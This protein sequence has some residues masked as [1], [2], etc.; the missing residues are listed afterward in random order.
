MTGYSF[1]CTFC[2]T[3]IENDV[4][5]AVKDDART[6]LA[7]HRTELEDVFALAFGGTD[8]HNDCGYAFPVGVDEVTGF[9]CPECGHDN[10]PPF[11]QQYIYWRIEA[12]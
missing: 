7:D 1:D 5:D 11:V 12:Q 8:C 4:A 9:D 2:D 10:F 3:V 6:H